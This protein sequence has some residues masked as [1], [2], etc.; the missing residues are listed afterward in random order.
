MYWKHK[1][2]M[3]H[4]L[5]RVKKYIPGP[6]RQSGL[7]TFSLHEAYLSSVSKTTELEEV[8]A[9]Q[10]FSK[11]IYIGLLTQMRHSSESEL[12]K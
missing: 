8:K 4:T 2:L 3:L 1:V 9:N 7:K 6:E 10:R 11:A 5:N 12:I